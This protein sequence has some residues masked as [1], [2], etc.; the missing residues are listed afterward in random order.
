MH[1][2]ASAGSFGSAD[3]RSPR[4]MPDVPS[5]RGDERWRGGR[6][7]IDRCVISRSVHRPGPESRPAGNRGSPADHRSV[8]PHSEQDC[9]LG[10]FVY[11]TPTPRRVDVAGADVVQDLC[12]AIRLT[13]GP[14]DSGTAA[15]SR[16]RPSQRHGQPG[17]GC[18]QRISGRHWWTPAA[19]TSPG[20]LSSPTSSDHRRYGHE[21]LR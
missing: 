12:C 21:S 14:R 19:S 18:R 8:C 5:K 17:P 4:R 7:R 15:A 16:H 3:R 11:S 1:S 20:R 2:A 13:W 6:P 10:G 9:P